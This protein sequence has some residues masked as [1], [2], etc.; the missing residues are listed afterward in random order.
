MFLSYLSHDASVTLSKYAARSFLAH[1]TNINEIIQFTV[2][3][4]N[5]N[6]ELLFLYCL[7]QRKTDGTLD[8]TVYSKPTNTGRYLNVRFWHSSATKQGFIKALVLRAERLCS[9][10]DLRKAEMERIF[11]AF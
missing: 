8:T 5:E 9:T 11:S 7:I 6:G 1:I 10:S 4:K 3:S 2:D